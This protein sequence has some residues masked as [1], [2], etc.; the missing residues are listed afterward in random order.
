MA[1]GNLEQLASRAKS[2]N[3]QWRLGTCRDGQFELRRRMVHDDDIALMN[4]C[5]G[6][7]A[8]LDHQHGGFLKGVELVDQDGR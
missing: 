3:L 2:G 1:R 8:E 6:D 7:Q 5:T 4:L